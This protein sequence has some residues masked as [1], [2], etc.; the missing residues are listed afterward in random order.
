MGKHAAHQPPPSDAA[1]EAP[2]SK[3][4]EWIKSLV[5]AI[6]IFLVLRT[7]LIEAFRIPSGSMERTLLIGDFLFV[8]KALYGAEIPLTGVR[9]P[10]LREPRRNDLVIFKS[11]EEAHLTVVKR[12]VGMPGDTLGMEDNRLIVNGE[13][14]AEPWAIRTDPLADHEDPKMRG[15][16]VRYLTADRAAA[17]YRPTL[18]NWGPIVVPADSFFV[19]GDNRD[20]SYD[21]R[22]WGFLGRDRIRGRPLIVY[23]SYDPN[24]VLPLPFLTGVRWGR[25]LDMPR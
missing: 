1:R 22:Y 3:T 9:L 19:M 11:V 24:G 16:Q 8:N 12:V 4:W 17:A 7:F 6:A 10:A 5:I 25:L 21:S 15:W 14:A 23:F 20:N 13:P 2:T 18:K